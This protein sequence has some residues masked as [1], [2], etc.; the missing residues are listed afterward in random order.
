VPE[1]SRDTI[2]GY[3]W[4]GGMGEFVMR[5]DYSH[6]TADIHGW[7]KDTY[8]PYKTKFDA[9]QKQ[10]QDHNK[11]AASS[12]SSYMQNNNNSNN[13]NSSSSGRTYSS[14]FSKCSV[15]NGHGYTEYDCGGGGGHPCRKY[16]S[17]CNG[18]GQVHN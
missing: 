16:C 15:C 12:I 9:L 3:F 18:T 5:E 1:G 11:A 7:V 14:S 10:T 2:D 6:F 17:A 4:H 13:N 8:T